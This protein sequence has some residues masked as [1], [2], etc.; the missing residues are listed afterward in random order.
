VIFIDANAPMYT[1]GTAHPLKAPSIKVLRLVQEY[2]GLFIT[3]AEVLQEIVHRYLAIR[4]WPR[5]RG[6]FQ[7]FARLMRGRIEPIYERDVREAA[8]LADAH[9]D[10]SARDLLH[11]AVMDRLGARR[12]VSTDTDFDY[13]P[14]L[15]RLDPMRVDDWRDSVTA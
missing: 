3:S 1:V 12:I 9:P 10:S 7:Q 6:V 2:P 4:A 13:L 14:G 5:G 15:E 11:A 8:R